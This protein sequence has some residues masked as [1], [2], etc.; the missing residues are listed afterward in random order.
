[1]GIDRIFTNSLIIYRRA[2]T[3]TSAGVGQQSYAPVSVTG[4]FYQ[5]R[6]SYDQILQGRTV[7][8]TDKAALPT[9]TAV[10][11]NDLIG[12]QGRK[13]LV[14]SVMDKHGLNS[15]SD[16]IECDLSA[17]NNPTI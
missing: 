4:R 15:G 11:V 1:M 5:P 12:Y 9:G 16:H 8:V 10:S 7:P 3:E 17:E 2:I 14:L 6:Q 13:Y